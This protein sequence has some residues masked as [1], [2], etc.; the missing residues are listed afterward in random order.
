MPILIS[1]IVKINTIFYN[2]SILVKLVN[3]TTSYNSRLF[4]AGNDVPTQRHY[5]VPNTPVTLDIQQVQ[6]CD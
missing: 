3:K 2:L 6:K 5:S 4:T 1:P